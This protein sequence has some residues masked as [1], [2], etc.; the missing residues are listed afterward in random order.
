MMD[1][2]MNHQQGIY[3]RT[4]NNRHHTNNNNHDRDKDWPNWEN[5]RHIL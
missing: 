2:P 1:Q 3:P 4:P 5:I